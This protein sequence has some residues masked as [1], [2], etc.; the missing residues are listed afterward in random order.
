MTVREHQLNGSKR[1][2]HF[3]K[4]S[5]SSVLVG[6]ISFLS[7]SRL[8]SRN[9]FRLMILGMH[10]NKNLSLRCLFFVRSSGRVVAVA[11]VVVVVESGRVQLAA[12][13]FG[14]HE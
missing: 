14:S 11:V 12:Q 10:T 8:V 5:E 7:R 2:A 1:V 9:D 4:L 6:A 3:N 13:G